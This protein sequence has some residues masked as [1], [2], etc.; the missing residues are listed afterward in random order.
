MSEIKKRQQ[1]II[2]D[3]KS[4]KDWED[5]YKK[6]IQIGKELP[7]FDEASKI[8]DNKVQGC[9][10]QVWIVA[11]MDQKN[12]LE[13]KA[14]SDA[15]I[16]RGLVGLLLKVYSGAPPAEIIKEAPEFISELGLSQHLSPSRAN[17]LM[18]MVKKMKYYAIAFQALHGGS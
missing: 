14:D 15:L 3:F 4:C 13:F 2:A 16:T 10:A 7:Q 1:Q 9:Q 5:R 12:N 6:I 11:Q 17:G 18:S 8:E